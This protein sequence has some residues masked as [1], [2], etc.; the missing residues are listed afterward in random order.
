VSKK[1]TAVTLLGDYSRDSWLT[2]LWRTG[3]GYAD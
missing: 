1:A 2:F 3:L